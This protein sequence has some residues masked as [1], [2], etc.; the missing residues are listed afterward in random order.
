MIE[1]V[2]TWLHVE[3]MQVEYDD[4]TTGRVKVLRDNEDASLVVGT[5]ILAGMTLI[6]EPSLIM[7]VGTE[8]F[9]KATEHSI[10]AIE[11]LPY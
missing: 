4:L 5:Q 1:P 9:I 3:D 6:V 11:N 8:S 2:N 10:Y 7:K